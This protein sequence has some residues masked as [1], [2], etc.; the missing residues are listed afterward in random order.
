MSRGT[1]EQTV[2]EAGDAPVA[3]PVVYP[4]LAGRVAVVTGGSRG[5]GASSWITGATLDIT[6]GRIML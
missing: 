1:S 4:D 6:G 3:G 5:I 2:P